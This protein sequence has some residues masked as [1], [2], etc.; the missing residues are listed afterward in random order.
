MSHL[1][2][3]LVD[4]RHHLLARLA[5]S[6]GCRMGSAVTLAPTPAVL[7]LLCCCNRLQRNVELI[8]ISL[9]AHKAFPQ[10]PKLLHP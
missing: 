5:C 1:T 2:Q 4:A 7:L 10:S 6:M 9:Q 8:S 3:V